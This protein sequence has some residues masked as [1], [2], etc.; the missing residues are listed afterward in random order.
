LV[1]GKELNAFVLP[2]GKIFVFTGLLPVMR[3]ADGIAAVLGHE[4]SHVIAGHSS[5][6]QSRQLLIS[7]ALLGASIAGISPPRWLTELVVGAGFLLPH[8]R[9]C[10]SEADQMGLEIMSKACFDP[11]ASVGMWERM[12]MLERSSSNGTRE[13]FSTHPTHDH[14]IEDLQGWMAGA[15]EARRNAGCPELDSFFRSS[16]YGFFL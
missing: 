9:N 15:L 2:N 1:Q 6:Q 16:R 3:D 12:K 10:E 8:S 13:F 5:E 4:L 7:L 14:R 11:R